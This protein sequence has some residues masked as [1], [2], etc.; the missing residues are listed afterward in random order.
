MKHRTKK[1]PKIAYRPPD[2]QRSDSRDNRPSVA[3][4][5]MQR[6]GWLLAIGLA[7]AVFLAYQPVWQGGFIWDDDAHVRPELQS[8]HG[9]ARIWCD[10]KATQQYYPL[11]H[12]AFWVEYRLFDDSTLGYHLI[13][14]LLHV[15]AAL[16]VAAILRRLAVP[17]RISR[18]RSSPCIRFTSSRSPGLRS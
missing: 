2:D 14:I 11:L 3:N 15:A 13:N 7:A 6:Q 8:W 9:L 5:F 10:L 16:L 4:W 1:R 12:S 17:G 18:R